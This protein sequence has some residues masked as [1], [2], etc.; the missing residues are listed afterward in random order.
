[1]HRK[2]A[3]FVCDE[4]RF[5][6]VPS[7]VARE[8]KDRTEHL[9]ERRAAMNAHTP[10]VAVT[11]LVLFLACAFS[12]E[13]TIAAPVP[14]PTPPAGATVVRE[15]QAGGAQVYAC[16]ETETGAFQWTLTGPKAVLI[17]D[18]GSDF[19]THSAGPTWTA[20]DGSTITGDGAHP[21]AKIDRFQSVPALLLKVASAHGDGVLS[22]VRF[23]RRTET[24]GGVA[25]ANGCDAAHVN[26]TVAIRYSAVYTFYR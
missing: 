10:H 24:A 1:V 21:L 5:A 4:S 26:T 23:V 11:A 6:R 20:V 14:E 12:S 18:D 16:R 17:N 2:A 3:N 25:P 7:E 13:S 9:S 22:G 19:G 8:Q 15:V